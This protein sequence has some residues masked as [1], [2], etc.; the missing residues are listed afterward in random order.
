MALDL[1]KRPKQQRSRN[2]VAVILA[3]A[4]RILE[5]GG[6]EALNTNAIAERAGVSIGSFYQYFPGKEPVLAEMIR[7]ERSKLLAEIEKQASGKRPRLLGDDVRAF[8]R[9]AV[10][11][12]LER[13]RLA[14]ALEY[15]EATL[16]LGAET[17]VLASRIADCAARILAHHRVPECRQAA[18]DTVAL[19][20]GMIDAAGLAGE[21]D[22][23]SLT[24]RVYRAAMGYLNACRKSQ[25]PLAR[26]SRVL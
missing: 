23:A 24:L 26:G 5:D 16:P 25:P 19:A 9:L 4:A 14:R 15:A 3:A 6:L 10:A 21:T 13:P 20:R 17:S 8:I 22:K 7:Q 11:H 12:Q 2:T 1:H 18:F